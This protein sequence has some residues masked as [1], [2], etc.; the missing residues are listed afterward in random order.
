MAEAEHML[1]QDG[2]PPQKYFGKWPFIRVL[3]MQVS[4]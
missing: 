1:R 2:V 4:M 3:G